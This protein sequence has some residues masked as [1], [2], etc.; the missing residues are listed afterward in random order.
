MTITAQGP[1]ITVVL[2]GSPVSS[3]NLD[4]WKVPGKR[5]DGSPHKFTN[6]AI[7]RLART[8]YVGFQDLKGNCWFNQIRLKKLSPGGISSPRSIAAATGKV[9][10]RVTTSSVEPYVETARFEGHSHPWVETIQVSPSGDHLLT[11]SADRTARVWEIATGRE[12][13]RLW[14]PDGLRPAAYHPDGHRVVTGCNDGGVRLWDLEAGKL[15]RTLSRHPGP[16]RRVAVSSDGKHVL[17]GGEKNTLRLL[18][19]ET[20][21]QIQQFDGVTTPIWSVAISPDGRRVLAGG[22]NGTIFVGGSD[23]REP[24]QTL[25]GHTATVWDLAFASDNRHAI[26]A[27]RDGLLIYWDTEAG[28]AIRQTKLSDT[29]IRCV[30][31][32][33]DGRHV[34]FG[35]QRQQ[36]QSPTQAV[37]GSMDIYDERPP[38]IFT[39]KFAHL[40][41]ALLPRGAVATADDGGAAR[42]WDPAP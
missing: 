39:Q 27:G 12:I 34:I 28:S 35:G 18:E 17:S 37:L 1:E 16:V 30:A 36:G 25:P 29:N 14:H 31:F 3:I 40:G 13:Q 22:A 33:K 15:I 32:E 20:G 9:S 5:P 42:I 6:I 10:P 19:V 4:E 38:H 11:A 2:N 7:A 26:S 21:R 24:L 41:L 8:G 23:S